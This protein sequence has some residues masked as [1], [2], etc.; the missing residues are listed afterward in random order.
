MNY[1]KDSHTDGDEGHSTAFQSNTLPLVL[2]IVANV[3]T[4]SGWQAMVTGE[5]FVTILMSR[6]GI[7]SRARST[8]TSTVSPGCGL[9][10]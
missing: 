4:C 3:D 6:T 1:F 2:K 5:S 7:N 10:S 9:A 8:E